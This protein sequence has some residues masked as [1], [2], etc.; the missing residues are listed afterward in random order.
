[1]T[2]TEREPSV[3]VDL[4]RDGIP[5]STDEGQPVLDALTD[6]ER[7]AWQ[8]TGDLPERTIPTS[9]PEGST[10]PE[11][12]AQAAPTDASTEPASEPGKPARPNAETRKQQLRAEIEDL[13]RQ[14]RQLRDEVAQARSG[15]PGRPVDASPAA[16]SPASV[17]T[18][19][20]AEFPDYGAWLERPGNEAKT[21]ESY[22]R[23]LVVHVASVERQRGHAEAM[24]AAKAHDYAARV[25]QTI[26][27]EP[28]FVSTLSPE[29]H[30]MVPL[31]MLPDRRTA[32]MANV[33]AQAVV[34]SD[35]AP[36][37]LRYLSQNDS[38]LQALKR[39]PSEAAVLRMIGRI[40]G[41]LSA[42]T[43]APPSPVPS[44]PMVSRAPAPPTTLGN[45]PAVPADDIESAL[46]AGDFDAYSTRMNRKE[47]GS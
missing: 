2:G 42:Q 16:P 32:T 6:A 4:L 46:A 10:P 38:V 27:Q 18:A 1:M 43:T 33:V 45:R 44:A 31:D 11:P 39:Q 21:Y 14:A 19:P 9:T 25:A 23:D 5:S 26:A 15:S 36:Q 47:L 34:D 12:A 22:T 17:P 41:T 29:V 30:D 3:E 24:K 20:D 8:L 35:Q 28:D 37:L 13:S 7:E 40:E